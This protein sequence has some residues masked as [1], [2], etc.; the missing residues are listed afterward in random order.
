MHVGGMLV[1][2]WVLSESVSVRGCGML[3]RSVGV[4]RECECEG[5]EC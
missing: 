4:V 1:D 5:V 2:Q 3:S